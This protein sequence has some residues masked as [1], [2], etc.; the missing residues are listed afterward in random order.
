MNI[1]NISEEY[2]LAGY[3]LSN[4]RD[5]KLQRDNLYFRENVNRLSQILTWEFSKIL[6]YD[7]DSINTPFADCNRVFPISSIIMV[8]IVRAGIP[9]LQVA[10][11]MIPI[12]NIVFC[13]CEKDAKGIRRAILSD[14]VNY[15]NKVLVIAESLMTSASSLLCCLKQVIKRGRPSIIAI[16]NLISTPLAIDN[17]RDFEKETAIKTLL[18]TCGI[19]EFTPGVRGTIPGLGDVGDLLYGLKK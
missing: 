2:K 4:L 14:E 15:E 13:T 19:D 17:I 10:S 7:R 1:V 12:E 6:E 11:S 18:F 5:C 9:I 8:A 16:L 3:Y